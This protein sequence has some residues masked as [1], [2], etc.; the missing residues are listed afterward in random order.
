MINN[1]NNDDTII[2]PIIS[3][4]IFSYIDLCSGVGGFHMAMDRINEIKSQVLLAADIN[5]KCRDV[6]YKNHE[7]YPYSDLTKLNITDHADFNGIFAGFSCQP[8]SYA[9]KR[10]GLDDAR[11]TI[12]YDIFKIIESKKPDM[13]CLENVKGLK[14]MKNKNKTGTEVMIYKYIHEH[15]NN[16][17]YFAYDR[18]ISPH[19]INIPQ[20]RERVV[21]VGIRKDLVEN[22]IKTLDEYKKIFDKYVDELIEKRHQKNKNYKVFEEEENVD[23][24]YYLNK[25]QIDILDVWRN[26]VSMSEWDNIDNKTLLETYNKITKKKTS[27]NF[28][29]M[30]FF[31]EFRNFQ[32]TREIPKELIGKKRNDKIPI[33]FKEISDIWNILYDNN[34]SIKLLIDRFLKDNKEK[35]NNMLLRNRFL[36]YSGNVDYSSNTDLNNMYCQIRQSGIRIRKSNSFPTLVKSGPRPI[37]IRH[38]RVLTNKEMSR[39]QSFKEDFKFIDDHSAMNQ[40]GN[41]VNVQVIEIMLRCAFYILGLLKDQSL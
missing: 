21:I 7:I 35:I 4:N 32:N 29:Q 2:D 31:T 20:K 14:S 13:V 41:A 10:L 27:K 12:I 22:K 17:N 5:K 33:N 28:K 15:M 11:G 3:N 37:I 8:F 24:K 26:F 16:L 25:N 36:E 1:C 6:Y 19:E 9:G 39:L 18:I 34:D 23:K 40:C 30:H 38:N